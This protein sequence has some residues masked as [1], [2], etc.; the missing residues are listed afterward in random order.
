VATVKGKC[1][2][3]ERA[4]VEPEGAGKTG[5]GWLSSKRLAEMIGADLPSCR[6]FR[7]VSRVLVSAGRSLAAKVA[8]S[9]RY[10]WCATE[11]RLIT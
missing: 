4:D 6:T 9:W 11:R 10:P 1:Q 8:F 2:S 5:D 7:I 3:D